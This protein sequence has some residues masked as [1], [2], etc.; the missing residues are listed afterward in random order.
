MM[1]RLASL[2]S[3]RLCTLPHDLPLPTFPPPRPPKPL[4]IRGRIVL[5]TSQQ[6]TRLRL[7][8]GCGVELAPAGDLATLGGISKSSSW[9]LTVYVDYEDPATLA[10][11][12]VYFSSDL[13]MSLAAVPAECGATSGNEV[14]VVSDAAG[15]GGVGGRTLPLADASALPPGLAAA[16]PPFFAPFASFSAGLVAARCG[17][18][19]RAGDAPRGGVQASPVGEARDRYRVSPRCPRRARASTSRTHHPGTRDIRP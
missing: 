15:C 14:S 2:A 8:G 16:R 5:T 4:P 7:C 17:D 3:R 9:S 12:T 13:R 10:T 11:T 18:T 6:F 1:R 19:G